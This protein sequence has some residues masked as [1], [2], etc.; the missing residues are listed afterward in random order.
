MLETACGYN[1]G[2]SIAACVLADCYG[3]HGK[4]SVCAILTISF[5]PNV[6]VTVL[7]PCKNDDRTFESD[8]EAG[9]QFSIEG[10]EVCHYKVAKE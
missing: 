6:D 10:L 8:D 1:S 5:R 2:D 9:N 3:E 7:P 4:R